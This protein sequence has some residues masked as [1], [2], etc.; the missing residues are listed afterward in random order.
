[1]SK[2]LYS[3][4][5]LRIADIC[6]YMCGRTYTI[7][8]L[9]LAYFCDNSVFDPVPNFTEQNRLVYQLLPILDY[10]IV[11]WNGIVYCFEFFL[12]VQLKLMSFPEFINYLK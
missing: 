9:T 3:G 10:I 7:F 5:K 12:W 11:Q 6:L 4:V 2:T 8:T 1:M